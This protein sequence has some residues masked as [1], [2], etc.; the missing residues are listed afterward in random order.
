MKIFSFNSQLHIVT[1]VQKVLIDIHRAIQSNYD[2]YILGTKSY[3]TVNTSHKIKG[4]EYFKFNNPFILINSIVIVH[5]RKYL[6]LFNIIRMLLLGRMKVLYI[7]HSLLYGQK[8]LTVFPKNIVAI[9][10]RGIENL[11]QYFNIQKANIAKIHNCVMDTKQTKH[12]AFNNEEITILY[13]ARI[14][15][16]KRQ[17]EIF[18]KLNGKID[19]RIKILF[20]GDG[21]LLKDL[22]LKLGDKTQFISL[23]YVD[24]VQARLL[25][26]D[27]MMLFSSF[28]GLPISLI[29]ACMC[30]CPIICNDVGGN[31]EIAF[32]K[33][34]A[35]V[36]NTWD[37]LIRLINSLP[38]LSQRDYLNMVNNSRKIYEDN[39][40]FEKFKSNYLNV[41][42]KL[43]QN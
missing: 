25:D 42:D 33:K 39:F 30:G 3:D 29:E 9:S 15:E 19:K 38:Y 35:F 31:T 26:V 11:T 10:D 21:P 16:G 13:P 22:Q 32:S 4:S 7:H 1:G 17:L 28:E 34:N 24:N 27:F 40:T 18:E 2:A 12:K 6:L 43:C 8:L 37:D 36:V 14:N 20:A 23:G 41:I 5:E